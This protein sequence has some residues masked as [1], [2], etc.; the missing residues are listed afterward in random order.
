MKVERAEPQYRQITRQLRELISSGA[1]KPGDRLPSTLDLCRQ[2]GAR[3]CTVQAAMVPL[4]REGL[5]QRLPRHG[6]TVAERKSR[7]L[8]RVA[9]YL[10]EDVF[11]DE[12]STFLRTLH[13]SL[14]AQLH[15]LGVELETWVDPRGH[16]QGRAVW[17]DLMTAAQ[18]RRFDA[19]IV[20]DLQASQA[21]WIGRLPVPV[22][23]MSPN[24]GPNVV[25]V[26]YAS[27]FILGLKSLKAQGCKG[28]G[29]ISGFGAE[30][31]RRSG[32][33]SVGQE[34]MESFRE[35]VGQLGLKVRDEWVRTPH[36]ALSSQAAFQQ[37]G[38]ES[39][40]ALWRHEKRPDGL[41]VSDDVMLAGVF[42]AMLELGIH[43]PGDL[44]LVGYKN[45]AI[46][47]F[48][49]LAVTFAEVSTDEIAKALLDQIQKQLKGE[50]VVRRL[51][52]PSLRTVRRVKQH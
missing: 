30:E 25:S 41:I 46:P 45:S 7:P 49:P 38:Y 48:T 21:S 51:I 23:C 16:A 3:P 40:H 52:P 27:V 6:T 11:R 37:F 33:R 9:V 26:D 43:T 35:T 36:K 1:L 19:L 13:N 22:A 2:W 18:N 29:V 17:G 39:M 42:S 31:I 34:A 10:T 20:P 4:V 24:A 12:G 5:L 44:K 8:S 14:K 15:K 28:I 47:V 50:P 32:A